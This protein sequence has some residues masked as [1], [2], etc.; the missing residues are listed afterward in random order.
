M[1]T[2]TTKTATEKRRASKKKGLVIVNTG[3]GKGKTTAALGIVMRAWGRGMNVGV[4]QFM[5]NEHARYGEIK[6]A[7]KMGID[8][9]VTGDGW[10]WKSRDIDASA[11]RARHGWELAQERILHGQYDVL[12]LDEFTYTMYF[13]WLDAADIVAWLQDNKPPML[14]LIITGRYAPAEL[15]AYADLV[16]EMCE[17]KHPYAEQGITAQAGIEF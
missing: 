12:L 7:A 9:M 5:K 10:T 1:T 4:I 6:A 15:I 2:S 17:I 13:G 8:W 16:T 11:D 3:N 14:H